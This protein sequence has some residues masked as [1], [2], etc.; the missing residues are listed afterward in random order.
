VKEE[1][2]PFVGESWYQNFMNRNEEV[3]TR[4][5]IHIQDQQRH[6]LCTVE[7]FFEMYDKIYEAM[8][9]CGVAENFEEEKMWDIDGNEVFDKDLM[10]GFP[11]Q[12]RLIKPERC[13]FVDEVGCNT[14]QT[15]D[16][17]VGGETFVSPKEMIHGSRNG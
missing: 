15:E 4:G 7:H 2:E 12:Y 14:N 8:I 11:S 9:L 10:Y 5:K 13:V 6:T 16:G 17:N 1:D 3:L